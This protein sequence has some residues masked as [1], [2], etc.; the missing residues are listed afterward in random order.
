MIRL[1]DGKWRERG[2]IPGGCSETSKSAL[3]DRALP[4]FVLGRVEDVD[5]SGDDGD[6]S[7]LE[8]AVMGGGI[9][10]SGEA[11]DD[12]RPR[13]AQPL[14]Q[15]AR[16]PAGGGRRVAGADHRRRRP[17]EQARMAFDDERRG[18][19]LQFGQQRRVEALAEEQI[20]GADPGDLLDLA[21]DRRARGEARRAAA[22]AGGEVGNRLQRRGGR[23]EAGEQLEIGYRSDILR[24]DQPQPGDLIARRLRHRRRPATR[25]RRRDAGYSPDASRRRAG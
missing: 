8:R 19:R 21:L 6:R 1:R 4:S 17:V 9:D 23:A 22:A 10:S 24:S 13:L 16:E 11:G 18:R 3:G 2:S 12:D 14:C 20:A 15:R 5:P 25:S 7:G